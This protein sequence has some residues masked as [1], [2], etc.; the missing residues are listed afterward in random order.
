MFCILGVD[1][2]CRRRWRKSVTG[3]EATCRAHT[4]QDS[5]PGGYR[6]RKTEKG[7][8]RIHVCFASWGACMLSAQLSV[9]WKRPAAIHFTCSAQLSVSWKRPA[10]IH[11]IAQLSCLSAGRDQQVSILF[12]QLSCLSAGRDQQLSI[13]FAQLCCLSA[14]TDTASISDKKC[15]RPRGEGAERVKPTIRFLEA[16]AGGIHH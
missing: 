1:T 6:A 10:G 9:S 7:S 8:M 12:A 2:A 13:L 14:G 11:F 16:E 3:P 15:D 5:L 4:M